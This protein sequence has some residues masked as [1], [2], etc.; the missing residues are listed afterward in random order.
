MSDFYIDIIERTARESG[1][2]FD[3]LNRF[4]WQTVAE[5]D[6]STM[7]FIWLAMEGLI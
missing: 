3:L 7:D 5:G 6:L 1:Y 4:F 2:S